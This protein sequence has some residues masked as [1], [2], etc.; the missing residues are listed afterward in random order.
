[1]VTV[2]CGLQ[3]EDDLLKMKKNT[4]GSVSL[5]EGWLKLETSFDVECWRQ[6]WE[7]RCTDS[8]SD[9][10]SHS[11]KHRNTALALVHARTMLYKWVGHPVG[12]PAIYIYIYTC[13]CTCVHINKY[14][15][16]HAYIYTYIYTYIYIYIYLSV[17]I[18]VCVYIDIDIKAGATH[19]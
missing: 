9:S 7:G 6:K 18:Y 12:E 19:V 8:S 1:M 14:I 10:A 3:G 2:T 13:T 17:H 4:R 16:D 11:Y 15:N 5:G